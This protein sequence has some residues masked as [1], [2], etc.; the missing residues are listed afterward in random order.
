MSEECR[1]ENCTWRHPHKRYC[2]AGHDTFQVGRTPR[3]VCRKCKT[4]DSVRRKRT[5]AVTDPEYLA[6]KRKQDRELKRHL[7][8]TDPRYRALA[9]NRKALTKIR[10][11]RAKKIEQIAYLEE[12]L[13]KGTA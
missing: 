2:P 4:R 3:A 13:R 5:R 11:R 9:I 8:A 6:R 1:A 7:Y 12:L 10:K